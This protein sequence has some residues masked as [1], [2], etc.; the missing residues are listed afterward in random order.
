[1]TSLF[2]FFFFFRPFRSLLI[3]WRRTG[4]TV[5][6][7]ALLF[8]FSYLL[9]IETCVCECVCRQWRCLFFARRRQTERCKR[10][11]GEWTSS[12]P[13]RGRRKKRRRIGN[14]FSSPTLTSG[15]LLLLLLLE[16]R[17]SLPSVTKSTLVFLLSLPSPPS[18]TSRLLLFS[19]ARLAAQ[20]DFFIIIII[21]P[22][23]SQA[24]PTDRPKGS[25]SLSSSPYSSDLSRGY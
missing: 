19:A 3:I 20:L 5:R 25:F 4:E 7:G 12:Y 21:R 23:S 17:E 15:L 13:W 18:Y 10:R 2:F 6:Y 22:W 1:M 11:E 8:S 24:K 9:L 14:T 16:G